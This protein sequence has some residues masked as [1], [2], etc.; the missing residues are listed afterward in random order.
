MKQKTNV[1]FVYSGKGGVGK[2]TIALNLAFSLKGLKVG[3]FDADLEG[4]SIPTLINKL[5]ADSNKI[6]MKGHIILPLNY[7]GVKVMSTGFIENSQDGIY[8]NG[9]NLEGAINQLLDLETWDVEVLI[10]DLPPGTGLIHR[11]LFEN[12]QGDC[13]LVT[14]PQDVCYADT[15]RGIEL[16]NEFNIKI[17]GEVQNMSYYE[18]SHCN[19]R[20]YILNNNKKLY[21]YG[22][23]VKR[24][25][26]F[27]IT[28]NLSN[29]NGVPIV[30]GNQELNDKFSILHSYILPSTN[31]LGEEVN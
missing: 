26:E 27:P 23:E 7:G 12:I 29:N 19:Q 22:N 6:R 17:I 31:N 1:I 16:I 3:L 5:K 25:L 11:Y 20:E 18:C 30:L 9:Y 21:S 24:L 14:T 8:L 4:P 2:S 13:V 15:Q 28:E 10:I